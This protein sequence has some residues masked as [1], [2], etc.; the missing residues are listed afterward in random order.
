MED[1]DAMRPKTVVKDFLGGLPF[2]VELD[3]YLRL[4]HKGLKSRYQ[5]TILSDHLDEIVTD[6]LPHSD[7]KPKGR[8]VFLFASGHYW[9]MHTTLCG[10]VLRGMGYDASLGYLPYGDYHKPVN[11]FDLRRQDLYTRD[12][13]KKADQ[14]LKVVPFLDVEPSRQIPEA[15]TQAVE[16]VTLY[17][18]QYILQREEVKGDEPVFQLRHERNIAAAR[19][20]HTYLQENRPDVVIVPN[21]M[22]Q[23]YGI[24]FAAA[25]ALGIPAVTYEF[26]EQDRRVWLEKN[27]VVMFHHTDADWEKLRERRLNQEQRAWVESFLNARQGIQVG[28]TFAHLYQK[29]T[30]TNPRTIRSTLGLDDRPVALLPTNVLGDSASLGRTIFSRSMADWIEQLIPFMATHTEVQ[31]VVRIHPSE[32]WTVGPSVAEIFNQTMPELPPHIHLI[33]PA[34]KINTYDLMDISDLALVYSTTAGLEMALR[35]IPVLMSGWAHYRNKGFTLDP[36]TWE[37][38]FSVL[39]GALANLPGHRLTSAQVET[40]W[41][42]TYFYFREFVRP[43]PWHIEK[44]AKDLKRDPVSYVLSPAGQAE[45]GHTFRLLADDAAYDQEG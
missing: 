41:N 26:G 38:Y 36:N 6:V 14:L 40:A 10:L 1:R 32:T 31:W 37:E 19:K 22:I 35:G 25:R 44:I 20:V 4:R 21:G 11:R 24:V 9:I 18:T 5:L 13:L 2:T 27:A 3:W 15:L 16:Q 42:Y 33:G 8:K 7:G 23:E 12:I 28:E 34:E 43:F 39:D 30:R 45:F 29:A 17:D